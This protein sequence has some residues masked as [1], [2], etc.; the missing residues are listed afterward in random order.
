MVLKL[1][2]DRHMCMLVGRI[3]PKRARFRLSS[4]KCLLCFFLLSKRADLMFVLVWLTFGAYQKPEMSR[5]CHNTVFFSL[6]MFA[7]LCVFTLSVGSKLIESHLLRIEV[8]SS[9]ANF[10]VLRSSQSMVFY[11][12]AHTTKFRFQQEISRQSTQ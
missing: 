8:F 11:V 12:Q 1:F 5:L 4:V 2:L 6:L 7:S 9:C 3:H 10:S